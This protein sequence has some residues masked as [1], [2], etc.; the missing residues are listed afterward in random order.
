MNYFI[1]TP[2]L[3]RTHKLLPGHGHSPRRN[4]ALPGVN[5]DERKARR[6]VWTA[7]HGRRQESQRRVGQ[8]SFIGALLA[9]ALVT[10]MALT[11]STG[12]LERANLAKRSAELDTP[13]VQMVETA[14]PVQPAP[15]VRA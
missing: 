2:Q 7:A 4:N 14:T 13:P 5:S 10:L 6:S 12:A 1:H 9:M 11:S 8:A 15:R 3:L